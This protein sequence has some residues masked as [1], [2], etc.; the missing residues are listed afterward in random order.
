MGLVTLKQHLPL[1]DE[2]QEKLF[3][4]SANDHVVLFGAGLFVSAVIHSLKQRGIAPKCICDNSIVKHGTKIESIP[5]VSPTEAREAFPEATVI[6]SAAPIH[7]GE[8]RSQLVGMGWKKI[9]DSAFLLSAFTY[10]NSTFASGVSALHLD[11]DRYFYEYFLYFYPEKT[12]ITSLDIV[13]TERC[14]LKC[15]DCSNLTQ[16]YL[17]PR[18]IDFDGLFASLDLIM[19]AVDHVLEFRVLGGET[20]MN[21]RAHQYIDRLRSY[22]NYTRIAVYSNGTIIPKGPNL[23]CLVHDDTYLRISDYGTLSLKIESMKMLFDRYGVVYDILKC[24]RWQNCAVIEKRTRTKAELEAVYSN[25]CARRLVTL[26]N[27]SLYICPFAANAAN[28]GAVPPFP[29]ESINLKKTFCV[30]EI[31][32]RLIAMLR[33]KPYFSIC[34]FCAGRPD[35]DT[36][37][38]AA[39]QVIKPLPYIEF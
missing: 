1:P 18:D 24:D 14:S 33:S 37:L 12:I 19:K 11:L 5:V 28:L 13:I 6:I 2:A 10:D 4:R 21:R 39:I 16:Y 15:R 26:L 30:E 3:Y 35:F 23:S 20:F 36:P 17:K 7:I 34:E 29:E 9:F 38:A 25:C 32:K 31:K 27:G 8:I 22:N